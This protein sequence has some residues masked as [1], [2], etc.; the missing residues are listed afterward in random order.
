MKVAY[1]IAVIVNTKIITNRSVILPVPSC[2]AK[3]RIVREVRIVVTA[4]YTTAS[5]SEST[6][7]GR[8]C[9]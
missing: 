2:I 3:R 1:I 9:G 6:G 4:I 8:W 5:L 7:R